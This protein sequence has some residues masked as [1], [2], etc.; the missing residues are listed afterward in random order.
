MVARAVVS[1]LPNMNEQ[2]IRSR[3][4]TFFASED[5]HSQ[6]NYNDGNFYYIEDVADILEKAFDTPAGDE[7]SM[8]VASDFRY[9]FDQLSDAY[10]YRILERYQHN[11]IRPADSDERAQLNRAIR[12]L[13]TIL[14]TWN[15]SFG[16]E[17]V[18]SRPSWGNARSQKEINDSYTGEYGTP[19]PF[20]NV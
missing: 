20:G 5:E 3:V 6:S 7:Q 8:V 16:H 9:A 10:R 13:A 4:Y 1:V 14:N 15:T 17:G 12:K 2:G 19:D 11:V 18:G